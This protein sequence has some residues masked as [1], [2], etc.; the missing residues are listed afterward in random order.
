[1]QSTFDLAQHVSVMTETAL[2]IS[3]HPERWDDRLVPWT[4]QLAKDSAANRVKQVLRI[5]RRQ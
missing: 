1:V 5:I 2:A 4:G 3:A